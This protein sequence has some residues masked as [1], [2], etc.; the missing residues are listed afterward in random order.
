M[1]NAKTNDVK[2]LYSN[3]KTPDMKKLYLTGYR[4]IG[5]SVLIFI[6]IL[7][8]C[9][10]S[11]L[12][13]FLTNHNWVS[14]TI[15]HPSSEKVLT[16]N[17]EILRETGALDKI[18]IEIDA[19]K[20]EMAEMLDTRKQIVSILGKADVANVTQARLSSKDAKEKFA[21]VK[22]I[23]TDADSAARYQ[24]ELEKL[25]A[26]E[27][28]LKAGL[29]SKTDAAAYEVN[30]AQLKLALNGARSTAQATQTAATM[31][32]NASDTLVANGASSLGALDFLSKQ[33]AL[34]SQL[35]QLDIQLSVH[36]SEL[37]T[38][39]QEKDKLVAAVRSL[40]ASP[41]AD[42]IKNGESVIAFFPYDN[43][44]SVK[45]GAPLYDC[46]LM[47]VICRKVGSIEK[48]YPVENIVEFPIFNTRFSRTLRGASVLVKLNKDAKN[49]S[50]ALV[51]FSNFKPLFF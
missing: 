46:Y 50:T 43:A 41:F 3:I 22:Q 17:S 20:K 36:Q 7:I 40:D 45:A 9:Y 48:I 5:A 29:I 30:I 28:N 1:F 32:S 49:S 6:A 26:V 10:A 24:Q 8:V 34:Q 15:V 47:F 14:P 37:A 11:I 31:S 25:N 21:L 27:E 18:N 33:M 23:N 12:V 16:L 38:A 39:L 4:W 51:L 2:N 42:V 19:T 13:F 35:A 44:E